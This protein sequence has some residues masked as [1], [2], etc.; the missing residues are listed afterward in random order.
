MAETVFTG[1]A[2]TSAGITIR[3]ASPDEMAEAIAVDDDACAL[4]DTVGLHFDIGPDHPF[5]QSEHARWHAA[6]RVGRVY[7]AVSPLVVGML[8]LSVLDG[9]RHLEQLS[10]RTSA[11]RRGVGRALLRRAVAW[12]AG[13]A[14]WLTT[15]AHVPWN[16][17]FYESAGFVVVPEA[18]CPRAIVADL[19]E[20]R[21]YL[22][23]PTQRIA[24]RRP[25]SAS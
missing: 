24:M 9:A 14:L 13:E 15:Y 16:R 25:A 19:E 22:P 7:L 10:V 11:M 8:V 23:A 3:R 5:A 18:D 2:M 1:L 17:P 12:A 6:A 4:Y 20:Q 21:R